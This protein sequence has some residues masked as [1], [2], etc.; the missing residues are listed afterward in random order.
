MIKGKAVEL[1]DVTKSNS[2][3][4]LICERTIKKKLE[5]GAEDSPAFRKVCM[6][7]IGG[8]TKGEF[9]KAK[10]VCD[11]QNEDF[12]LCLNKRGLIA[13]WNQIKP[14]GVKKKVEKKYSLLS[15]KSSDLLKYISHRYYTGQ[16]VGAVLEIIFR[17][18]S[19][20]YRKEYM[21]YSDEERERR[22]NYKN[23]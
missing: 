23:N 15:V 12:I 14:K 10:M 19:E 21:A 22:Y 11:S 8:F 3:R 18:W 1:L 4:F 5:E 9:E 16:G 13:G 7:E 6:K 20:E 17:D 2:E